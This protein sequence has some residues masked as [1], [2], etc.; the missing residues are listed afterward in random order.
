M[1]KAGFENSRSRYSTQEIAMEY[2]K[3]LY[4]PSPVQTFGGAVCPNDIEL[5]TMNSDPTAEC[6]WWN[7]LT[8]R[9]RQALVLG[10]K[11]SGEV[12]ANDWLDIGETNRM[13]I[14]DAAYAVECWLSSPGASR[15]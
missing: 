1:V 5:S 3:T 2:D 15:N 12:A 6:R 13:R 10:A 11:R 14:L 8:P 4:G 9:Q 7:S